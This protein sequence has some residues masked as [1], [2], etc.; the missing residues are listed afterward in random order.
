MFSSAS[1][2]D[3]CSFLV[4]PVEKKFFAGAV[5]QRLQRRAVQVA[6][7]PVGFVLGGYGSLLRAS[8]AYRSSAR[9]TIV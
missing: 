9:V 2:A 8:F 4:W 5:A 1:S 6:H 3:I 7:G